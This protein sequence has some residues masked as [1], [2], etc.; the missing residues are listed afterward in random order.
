M[1]VLTRR[2]D[3]T[4]VI[5]KGDSQV[6]VR[7]VCIGRGK[8]RLGVECKPEIKVLRGELTDNDQPPSEGAQS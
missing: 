3:E 6:V 8:V 7:V 5:G 1:L 4:L 2:N